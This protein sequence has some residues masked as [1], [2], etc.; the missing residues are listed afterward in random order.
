M[1]ITNWEDKT[2]IDVGTQ[3]IFDFGNAIELYALDMLRESKFEFDTPHRSWK[4]QKPYISG[5]EDVMLKAED[6]VYYPVEIKGLNSTDFERIN[7]V[8]DMIHAKSPWLRKYPAQ[9]Q[10]YLYQHAKPFG[11]FMLINKAS[12]KPKFIDV[13][14]DYVYTE[15]IL[16][17]AERVYGHIENG[18]LPEPI[19]E[20]ALCDRCPLSHI[21]GCRVDRGTSEILVDEEFEGMLNRRD[22]LQP[23]SKEFEDLDKACK[24]KGKQYDRLFCG[25]WMLE[26]KIIPIAEKT[27][28]TKA[29]EQV[30]VNIRKVV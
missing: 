23:L 4:I 30:R 24:D 8:E 10:M 22:E 27:T 2:K 15:S 20:M 29:Y 11:M 18:T 28:T 21:C 12:G 5:R 13:E 3:F 16:Q 25:G 26:R 17:K 1:S 6:G 19:D 14:L 7:N 9:L